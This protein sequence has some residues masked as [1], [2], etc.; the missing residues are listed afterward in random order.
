M[1]FTFKLFHTVPV[2]QWLHQHVRREQNV[3]LVLDDELTGEKIEIGDGYQKTI[4]NDHNT[5]NVLSDVIYPGRKCFHS[6]FVFTHFDSP[7]SM[8]GSNSITDQNSGF[9]D[10]QETFTRRSTADRLFLLRGLTF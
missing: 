4:A 5:V 2:L 8:K 7:L 3:L 10:A 1:L 6:G 9:E